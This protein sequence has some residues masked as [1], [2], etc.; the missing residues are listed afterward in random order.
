[1]QQRCCGVKLKPGAF[2]LLPNP[3]RALFMG[4][5]FPSLQQSH[6]PLLPPE[7]GSAPGTVCRSCFSPGTLIIYGSKRQI[8]ALDLNPLI[9]SVGLHDFPT[10]FAGSWYSGVHVTGSGSPQWDWKV[11]QSDLWELDV[12]LCSLSQGNPGFL[13]VMVL[14]QAKGKLSSSIDL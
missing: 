1:M 9:C 4:F 10:A 13:D 6:T 7:I 5:T 8:L 3:L 11:L 2:C 14:S 12:L